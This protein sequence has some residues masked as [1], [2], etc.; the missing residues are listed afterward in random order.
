MPHL[1]IEYFC[2]EPFDRAPLLEAVLEVAA[3][4]GA[5]QREDIKVRLVPV[6]AIL[7][8][9]GRRSFLHATLSML[10]GRTDEVKLALAEALT[11]K[12]RAVCPTID[13]ISVDMRDMNPACYKKSLR[14][15]AG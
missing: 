11:Q 10:A 9:D 12:M 8:G 6:E 7:F 14:P 3:Q 2:D 13:A 15:L 4:S 1:V 5:M